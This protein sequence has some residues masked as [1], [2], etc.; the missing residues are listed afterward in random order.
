MKR[1]I[2]FNPW[3][4]AAFLAVICGGALLV[5]TIASDPGEYAISRRVVDV[6]YEKALADFVLH[7]DNVDGVVK[8][9]Y[10]DYDPVRKTAMVTVV[11]NPEI[12]TARIITVWLGNTA[13]I[14]ERSVN[15]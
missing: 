8:A 10:D 2:R 15:V 11:Y 4:T 6:P 7:L 13:S 9:T 1:G 3:T 12:T 14:W 5:S